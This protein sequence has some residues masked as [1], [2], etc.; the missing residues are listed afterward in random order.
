[1]ELI[2]LIKKLNEKFMNMRTYALTIVNAPLKVTL[3][4]NLNIRWLLNDVSNE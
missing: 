4:N 3:R 1:M 2:K